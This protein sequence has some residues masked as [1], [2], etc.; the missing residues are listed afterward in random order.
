[1]DLSHWWKHWPV[2]IAGT[3]PALTDRCDK[4]TEDMFMDSTSI[5][6][7]SSV[8]KAEHRKERQRLALDC[9]PLDC[10]TSHH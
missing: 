5:S 4:T 3:G 10:I 2:L 7:V 1:M 6:V 9:V 8:L